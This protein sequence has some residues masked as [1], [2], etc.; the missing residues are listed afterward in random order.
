MCTGNRNR[1]RAG[2]FFPGF[3]PPGGKVD[4]S[5]KALD[6]GKE[7]EEEQPDESWMEAAWAR[8]RGRSGTSCGFGE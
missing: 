6:F 4:L 8:E 1:L 3:A 5:I 7:A 2:F